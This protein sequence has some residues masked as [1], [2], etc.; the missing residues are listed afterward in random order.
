MVYGEI[1]K[2]AILIDKFIDSN[3]KTFSLPMKEIDVIIRYL[4]PSCYIRSSG[5]V[6][7][8]FKICSDKGAVVLK[9]GKKEGIENDHKVYKR[10]PKHIRRRYFA[11]IF[12]H[13]KYCLLQ[14]YGEEAKL[15]KSDIDD[16]KALGYRYG[17]SD[18]R[19]ENIRMIDGKLK[20]IDANL[21]TPGSEKIKFIKDVIKSRLS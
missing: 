10:L 8:V 20:I 7:T 9:I 5:W 4:F 14:E 6:K 12:W 21:F 15:A 16:L 3:R 13:T 19:K 17:L 2:K 11:K 1:R 18:I